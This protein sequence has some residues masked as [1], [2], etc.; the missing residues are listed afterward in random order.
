MELAAFSGKGG[1]SYEQRETMFKMRG[2]PQLLSL[3]SKKQIFLK[4]D[5]NSVAYS[6]RLSAHKFKRAEKDSNL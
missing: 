1:V 3:N 6:I 4:T 2:E 5:F